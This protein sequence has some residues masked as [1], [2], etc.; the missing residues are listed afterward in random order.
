VMRG[1][2]QVRSPGDDPSCC[3]SARGRSAGQG[4]LSVRPAYRQRY[5]RPGHRRP[6]Q[7]RRDPLARRRSAHRRRPLRTGKR[8]ASRSAAWTSG[9]RQVMASLASGTCTRGESGKPWLAHM[10]RSAIPCGKFEMY[11]DVPLV[12]IE[13]IGQ[14]IELSEELLKLDHSTNLIRMPSSFARSGKP[15]VSDCTPQPFG[16]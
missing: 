4:V 5:I 16:L 1:P 6:C 3:G 15:V 11:S 10:P 8:P 9:H 12:R 13:E 14:I 7:G 2:A